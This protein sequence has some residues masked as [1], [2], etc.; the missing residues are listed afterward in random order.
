MDDLLRGVAA[1]ARDRVAVSDPQRTLT[2]G[3]LDAAA[4]SLARRL[5]ALGVRPGV[6]VAICHE[7][8]AASLA[9]AL[10]VLRAGG[11]YVG[12]D[13]AHPDARL[14]YLVADAGAAVLLAPAPVIARLG[15]VACPVL[16]LDAELDAVEAVPPLE[17]KAGPDDVAYVIYTS[18]ST[19]EPKGV[20]VSHANLRALIDWH[21]DAFAVTAADRASVVASPAFDASVWETWPY[22]A[23]GASLHVPDHGT[24][25]TPAALQRWLVD[26]RITIAFV[27]TPM[28][29]LLLDLTWPEPHRAAPD[30]DRRRRAP[31]PPAG[32]PAVHAGQQLRRDRG[33]GRLHVGGRADRRRRPAG[34]RPA[35]SPAPCCACCATTAASRPP[36]S[37]ASC[38]SAAA[39]SRAAT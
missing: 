5:R 6:L 10:A 31:P 23:S 18:G 3:E 33:D 27:P 20:Q 13:P 1:S 26:E 35:R 28:A 38:T 34:H 37:P 24:T 16:D 39:A 19:G 17:P 21:C 11:G 7:R 2:Y 8:S 12:L 29:E 36:A 22:L 25:V 32:G 14:S 9:G 4:D 15:A 30:A